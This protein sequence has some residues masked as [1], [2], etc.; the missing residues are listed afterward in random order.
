MAAQRRIEAEIGGGAGLIVLRGGEQG[1]GSD[2][3]M[4]D[5]LTCGGSY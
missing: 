2:G 3:M 4:G 5:G 1:G